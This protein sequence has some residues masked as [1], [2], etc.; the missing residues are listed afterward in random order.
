MTEEF[1][2]DDFMKE[3]RM[4]EHSRIIIYDEEHYDEFKKMSVVER[5]K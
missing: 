4:Y 3:K 5:L 2:L 1:W